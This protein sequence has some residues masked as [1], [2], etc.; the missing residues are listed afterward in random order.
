MDPRLTNLLNTS[1]AGFSGL[2]DEQIDKL[3]N[4][5]TALNFGLGTDFSS[6][7]NYISGLEDITD[8]QF[9]QMLVYLL[10][11]KTGLTING[12]AASNQVNAATGYYIASKIPYVYRWAWLRY[13]NAYF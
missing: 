13:L 4:F 9:Q 6:M 12:I 3:Q 11:K 7:T 2:K 5:L 8:D 10:C 1:S